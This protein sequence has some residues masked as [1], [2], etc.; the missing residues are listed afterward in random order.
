MTQAGKKNEK[1][2]ISIDDLINNFCKEVG[3]G[4]VHKCWVY[5]L[6]WYRHSFAVLRISTLP[7]CPALDACLSDIE[8]SERKNFICNTCWSHLNRKF[9]HV[10]L[11]IERISR[12]TT[13]SS[14][15]VSSGMETSFTKN[16]I[17]ESFCSTSG[18]TEEIRRNVVNVPC[19]TMN[20]F[21]V[22]PLG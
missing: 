13:T 9:C 19:D 12:N 4:P 20:T 11:Q 16:T 3:I 10:L 2:Q 17:H 5:D 22:F 18:W 7:D 14:R 1:N 8:Q 21:Q 15:F 6:L